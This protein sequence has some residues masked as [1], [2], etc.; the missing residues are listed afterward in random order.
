MRVI[1]PC[2]KGHGL[3][4][5]AVVLLVTTSAAARWVL[6]L[7]LLRPPG[8]RQSS[9]DCAQG[10][11]AVGRA[12]IH[13]RGTR[14]GLSHLGNRGLA[15]GAPGNPRRSRTTTAGAGALSTRGGRE[16][17]RLSSRVHWLR[18]RRAAPGSP[19]ADRSTEY[20]STTAPSAR[21]N[22][23]ISVQIAAAPN[24]DSAHNF[25]GASRIVR[26]TRHCYLPVG[27]VTGHTRSVNKDSAAPAA[28]DRRAGTPS[29]RFTC[30]CRMSS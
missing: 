6:R 7:C 10:V 20:C 3:H 2:P 16:S 15:A 17:G 8:S 26:R 22:V 11:A 1:R 9:A 28:A 18:P 13:L 19:R 25:P 4:P 30:C 21:Q 5:E 29:G 14:H 27:I 24:R 23:K 12:P